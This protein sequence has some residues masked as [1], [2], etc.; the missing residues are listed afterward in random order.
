MIDT[1]HIDS[2]EEEKISE[3]YFILP[4]IVNSSFANLFATF[5]LTNRF[6]QITQVNS[7]FVRLFSNSSLTFSSSAQVYLFL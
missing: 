4:T 6:F 1:K 2:N 3:P 5:V 7:T